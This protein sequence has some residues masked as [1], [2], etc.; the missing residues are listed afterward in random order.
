V[1]SL[2]AQDDALIARIEASQSPNHQGLDAFTLP[3]LMQRFHVPGVSVAVILDFKIHWVKAYGIADVESGRPVETNT[4]FQA[5][6]ISKPVAAMAAMRPVD[7]RRFALDDDINTILKSWH[8]PAQSVTPRSLMS[9]TSGADDGFGFPGYDPSAPRPT[10][11]RSSTGSRPRMSVRCS[12]DDRRIKR[13][14]IR[15]VASP[16]CR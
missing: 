12:S 7:E 9:H 13:T 16:S 3:E 1:L 4:L 11:F 5:A 10:R 8:V 15:V 2:G 6:S 14:S